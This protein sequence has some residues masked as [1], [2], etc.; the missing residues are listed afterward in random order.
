M[1]VSK[2]II[3]LCICFCISLFLPVQ[4]TSAQT[5]TT[6]ALQSIVYIQA[7]PG[8]AYAIDSKGTT[9]TWGGS[10]RYAGTGDTSI[11]LSPISFPDSTPTFTSIA[12]GSD[13]YSSAL[14]D[15]GLVY[16]WGVDDPS[17]QKTTSPV[18]VQ[19]LKNMTSI[20]TGAK[21]FLAL[22][23][24]GQVWGWGSNDTGQL[25]KAKIATMPVVKTPI[26][27]S[28]LD[29]VKA[30]ASYDNYSI[31]LKNDGTLWGWGSVNSS[32]TSPTLL[33]DGKNINSIHMSYAKI[34]ATNA[35]G[36]V[37]YWNLY[38]GNSKPKIYS[39][40]SP[41]I[42]TDSWAS[43]YIYVITNDHKVWQID[44]TTDPTSIQ[45]VPGLKDI[46]Q[47]TSGNSFTLALDKTGF[48][49]SLGMNN[50]GQLGIGNP[51]L[52]GSSTPVIVQK[53][54]DVQLNG[55]QLR[56]SNV[57]ILINSSVYVPVRGL[58]EKMNATVTWDRK[59]RNDVLVTSGSTT[60][61][62]TKGKN[63]AIVN[64]K[65]VPL[66]APPQ[67]ANES[68]FI[69]LRF[70]SETIGAHVNWNSADYTV[71]INTNNSSK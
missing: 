36:Q 40:K 70:I 39:L 38:K 12:P 62:L 66:S 58:F 61:Q 5:S 13:V 18:Q 7:S 41:V 10:G 55:Q 17:G 46:I 71:T 11:H 68:I 65:E 32:S 37:M 25:D 53:A 34:V 24:T 35:K 51:F 28:G 44:P 15:N 16:T 64:G 67:Y 19:D 2:Y 33:V 45:Q 26:R 59:N 49:H 56:M 57:P 60:I 52:R 23:N 14:T 63:T 6:H 3:P 69:P 8:S 1:K 9:W 21:H 30:I 29:Q 47:V 50:A 48:V 42:S 31:A 20:A 22:D 4:T 54:I 27:L 43:S